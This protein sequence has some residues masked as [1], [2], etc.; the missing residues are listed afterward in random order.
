MTARS[1]HPGLPATAILSFC[2]NRASAQFRRRRLERIRRRSKQ[3]LPEAVSLER[4]H[5]LANRAV[6]R[7]AKKLDQGAFASSDCSPR[8][9]LRTRTPKEHI[10][11]RVADAARE[12][13]RGDATLHGQTRG[14][15]VAGAQMRAA[16]GLVR[17]S[18]ER[19]ACT[20]E[21][22]C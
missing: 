18:A 3:A 16:R 19:V 8:T 20:A 9:G 22:V 14:I 1:G 6:V 12:K 15:E 17:W 10:L 21:P 4:T 13:Q 2:Q 5:I 7:S 11:A